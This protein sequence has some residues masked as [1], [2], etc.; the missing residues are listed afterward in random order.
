MQFFGVAHGRPGFGSDLRDGL[1]VQGAG[2]FGVA[3]GKGTAHLD[4]AGAALL[5]RRV[6]QVGVRIGVQD[7]V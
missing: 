1:R 4:R 7:F 3:G 2:P 6:I 5:E